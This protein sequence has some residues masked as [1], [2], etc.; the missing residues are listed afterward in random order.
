MKQ[1][2]DGHNIYHDSVPF[3][4]AIRGLYTC[5]WAGTGCFLLHVGLKSFELISLLA[6]VGP[7]PLAC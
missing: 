2:L 7:F 6:A 1:R 3:N 5:V 4:E